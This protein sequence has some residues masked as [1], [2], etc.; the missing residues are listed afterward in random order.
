VR[1]QRG[2]LFTPSDAVDYTTAT[3]SVS[4]VVTNPANPLPNL[5]GLSPAYVNQ[6][7]AAFTLKVTGTG[8]TSN[9]TV[10]W[11]TSA[12]TTQYVSDAQINAQVPASDIATSGSTAVA[13]QTPAPGGGTSN[14]MQFEVDSASSGTTPPD[15]TTLTASVTPGSSATYPVTLPSATNVSVTCL[16]LPSGATCSY[17]STTNVVTIVTSATTPAGTYQITVVFTETVPGTASGVILLPILVLPIFFLRKKLV[18]DGMWTSA[19]LSLILLAAVTLA[20]GCGGGGL[21]SSSSTS[22]IPTQQVTS[23]GTVSLTIQ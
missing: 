22:T 2:F 15:F 16:N 23:S 12:L 20:T 19:C 6:G 8:F 21:S 9:S 3:A 5:N 1:L 4:L 10:Y 18:A 17:S 13:V 14:S 7:G 11:G